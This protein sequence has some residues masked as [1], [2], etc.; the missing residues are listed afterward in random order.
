MFNNNKNE[1]QSPDIIEDIIPGKNEDS[2]NNHINQNNENNQKHSSTENYNEKEAA[3][4]VIKATEESKRNIEQTAGMQVQTAQ[5]NTDMLANFME[6]QR[7]A[8]DS[9]QSGFT[10]FQNIQNQLLNNQDFIKSISEMYFRLANNYT[11]SLIA[12][13]KMW[14][15]IAFTNAVRHRNAA[16]NNTTG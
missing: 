16:A 13:S 1:V 3:Q 5:T 2:A 9:F 8:M 12:Y 15:D 7:Q 6:L 14:N 11:E 4:A 10:S